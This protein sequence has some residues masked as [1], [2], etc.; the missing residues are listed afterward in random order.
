MAE[1][2]TNTKK[3]STTSR[4][5]LGSIFKREVVKNRKNIIVFDVRKRYK[6]G[7]RTR[8]PTKRC[9]SRHETLTVL[10][11]LAVQYPHRPP[12]HGHTDVHGKRS[13]TYVSF[14][15]AKERCNYPNHISYKRYGGRG[16]EFR[17]TSFQEFLD[18]LGERPSRH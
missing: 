16:I 2:N 14:E 17:F 11:S 13:L 7:E 1:Q 12:L 18:E 15:K 5:P 6:D 9:Y 4:N 3:L 8:D 10:A